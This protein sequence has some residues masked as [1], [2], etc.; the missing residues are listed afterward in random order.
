MSPL[1]GS[2]LP[3]FTDEKSVAELIG[4]P[5]TAYIGQSVV[6][7]YQAFQR[8]DYGMALLKLIPF[9]GLQNGLKALDA[10]EAGVQTGA[11]RIIGD[12]LTNQDLLLMSLGFAAR[13]V[14]E[15]R[16][17]MYRERYYSFKN[18]GV[19]KSYVN[20]I[21]RLMS[22]ID[23]TESAEEKKELYEEIQKL[24]KEVYEHDLTA[25]LEDKIDPN[26]TIVNNANKRYSDDKLGR[27]A[28]IPK[29]TAKTTRI[30]QE[31]LG[32]GYR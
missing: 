20:K 14:Y 16:D 9:A 31:L 21:V 13:P 4:G 17:R 5:A 24:Y 19:R 28:G 29:Q 18:S 3:L 23:R 10:S 2:F 8:G 27:Q 7:S 12:G 32:G 1:K 25:D 11:G 6:G 30:Q 26:Y 15:D 22:Q